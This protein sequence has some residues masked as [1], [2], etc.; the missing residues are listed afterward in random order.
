MSELLTSRLT[1]YMKY[2]VSQK[3]WANLKDP[4]RAT[5]VLIRRVEYYLRGRQNHHLMHRLPQ[6]ID[7]VLILWQDAGNLAQAT[8]LL[9]K[10]QE[11]HE[12]GSLPSPD[13]RSF[14]PLLRRWRESSES[15]PD[16]KKHMDYLETKIKELYN[17]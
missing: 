16:R 10:L 9:K 3:G 1:I 4:E 5:R 12:N 11:L 2:I 17:D 14:Y 13:P 6:D 7:A 8:V 15:H